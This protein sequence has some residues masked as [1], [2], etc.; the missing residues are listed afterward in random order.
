MTLVQLKHLIELA[1]NGSFSQSANKLHLTQPALSR[2]IKALE[3][4]LGQPLF[5][6]VGRKNELTAFGAHIVQRARVLVD[7]ANELRQ[8]SLQL[9]KGEI[10]QFRVGMGSGPGAMLMTPLLMLMATE[11]PQAHIEISRG[12]TTLLVQALRERTLDALVLD[13]RSLKPATD[14]KIEALQE[15]KGA[16]MCRHGHPLAKKRK[17]AF[18]QLRDYAIASTP[19]SDEVARLLIEQFGTQAHPDTLVNLR[20][21]EISSLLDVAR[22][23]DAIVLAIR[24]SAPD[25]VEID[26]SPALN[27][28]ARFGLI[29]MASR[30]EPPL[31]GKVRALMQEVMKD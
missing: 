31:L 10:G 3:D 9:Q 7:E 13:I 24:A 16:F 18:A 5:D 27:A 8:T 22:T 4:E 15:M 11:Y 23:S 14:L 21:E 6:R 19:L 28:N 17:V 20:C 26:L 25:L 30:T 1:T 12:S 2:S 29:T